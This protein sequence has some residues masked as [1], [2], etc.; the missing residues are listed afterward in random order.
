MRK[1]RVLMWHQASDSYATLTPS[2]DYVN[3]Y[4]TKDAADDNGD[5]SEEEDDMSSVGDYVSG[6][7]EE[8]AGQ[9]EV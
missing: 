6:E 3:K 9:M 7:D 1:S 4:A 8:P 5:D 2:Q